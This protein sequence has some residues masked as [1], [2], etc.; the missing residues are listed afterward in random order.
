M[1]I[2]KV[3]NSDLVDTAEVKRPTAKIVLFSI[4]KPLPSKHSLITTCKVLVWI[5]NYGLL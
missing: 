1:Y 5:L 3:E 2:Q 4:H